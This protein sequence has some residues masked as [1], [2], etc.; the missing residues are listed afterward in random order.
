MD[1]GNS[2]ITNAHLAKKAFVYIRQ[3]T[4]RQ[5]LENNESTMRQYDLKQK[6]TNLGWPPD[7]VRIIDQDLGKSGADSR[8]RTGFQTLVAEVSNGL[9]GAVACIECSRLSRDSEDWIRLTKFCAYTNTLL[10]DA[11]G[12]YDPND[13]NDSLLLGLKGTMSEAELHFLRERMRGGLMNKVG[14]GELRIPIPIGYM[15]DGGQVIKDPDIEI[16][17]AVELAFE[18]FH[19]QGAATR[20]VDHFKNNGLKFPYKSGNGFHNWDTEWKALD[21]GTVLRLFHNPFYAGVYYYG[22]HQLTWTPEGK[23]PMMMPRDQWHVFIS[24]HH[25]PYISYE[26]YEQNELTIASNR[27]DL[28]YREE[29]SPPREGVALLQGLVYCGKCGHGMHVN[30]HNYSGRTS[31]IYRCQHGHDKYREKLCQSIQGRI[32]DEKIAELLID[33]LTPEAVEQ[34]VNVQKELDSR[35]SE[36]LA[37]FQ[38]RVS[39]CE[40]EVGLARRRYMGVDPENRLVALQLESAWNKSLKALDDAEI[41]FQRQTEAAENAKRERDL[42][43][44]ENLPRSFRESFLSD[45]VSSRDKKRIV[46]YLIE[47]VTLLKTEQK[48]LIQVRFKGGTSQVIEIDAPINSFKKLATDPAVIRYIDEA[49]ETYCNTEIAELLNQEGLKTG[50][51]LVFTKHNVRSLMGLYSIPSKKERYLDRGYITAEEKAYTM[52]ISHSHLHQLLNSGRYDGDFV[53]VNTKN[54]VL[55]PAVN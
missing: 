27:L 15:Y 25:D 9:V 43:L 29:G 50:R 41:E 18:V 52:G 14:R 55:F 5:V 24:D 39:K 3:S 34:A 40:Y 31:P 4:Q 6:L 23:K 35:Q 16:Q 32:I 38:M 37:F 46:R 11:D 2:K 17:R 1:M 51:G 13:F 36:T 48:I 44:M 28:K 33:R 53:R 7:Q 20:V 49:A 42:S 47:D 8:D 12:V 26:E 10:I 45:D 22:R 54:E 21:Y 30:Y 19:R